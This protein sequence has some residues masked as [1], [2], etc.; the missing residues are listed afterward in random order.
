M[1]VDDGSKLKTAGYADTD[2]LNWG[3]VR[4]DYVAHKGA[5]TI[6]Q[7]AQRLVHGE[8]QAAYGHPF[9]D[10]TRT[11]RIFGAIIDGWLRQQP[12]FEH[13]P[14]V[15]D[16]PPATACLMMVGVKVSREVNQPK[17]DNRVDGAGYFACVDMCAER[18]AKEEG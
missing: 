6:L 13:I 4:V 17:R 12:G 18:Q 2:P 7:E 16:V 5:E 10:Y 15:P 3:N 1:I 14:A 8:R 11:G 9:D